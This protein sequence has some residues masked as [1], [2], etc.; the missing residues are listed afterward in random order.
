MAQ[1]LLVA[2]DEMNWRIRISNKDTTLEE[3]AKAHNSTVQSVLD[4]LMDNE[5]PEH[6]IQSSGMEFGKFCHFQ[7]QRESQVGLSSLI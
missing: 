5:L 4:F 6:C 1:Q 7:A 3:V 2:I